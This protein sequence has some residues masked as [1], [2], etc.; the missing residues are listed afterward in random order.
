[1]FP[2]QFT[3]TSQLLLDLV[4]LLFVAGALIYL[5]FALIM[6]RQIIIMRKT[7]ITSFSPVIL[8][9]GLVH[10]FVSIVVFAFLIMLL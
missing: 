4:G 3:A 9:L 10:L 2:F 5:V 6:V 1:M 7:L 8:T